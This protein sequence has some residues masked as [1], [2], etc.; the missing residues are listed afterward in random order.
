LR[1]A[2]AV[3]HTAPTS[4]PRVD[5]FYEP[6]SPASLN[7]VNG[8]ALC[9]VSDVDRLRADADIAGPTATLDDVGGFSDVGLRRL[10]LDEAVDVVTGRL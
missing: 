4:G 7:S 8:T 6:L 10:R 1:F 9:D 3:S 2:A 5:T